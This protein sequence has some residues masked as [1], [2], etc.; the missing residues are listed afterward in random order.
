MVHT[1]TV[2]RF[3][4]FESSLMLSFNKNGGTLKVTTARVRLLFVFVVTIK[5]FIST[6]SLTT[7][8]FSLHWNLWY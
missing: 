2:T 8:Q 5:I 3:T 4:I 7:T 6:L 1:R